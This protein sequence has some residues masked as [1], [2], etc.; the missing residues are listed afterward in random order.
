M[1]PQSS[2]TVT[3]K[4]IAVFGN[5]GGGKSRL[6]R[7]LAKATGLPL[8]C[9]DTIQFR[10]GRYWPREKGGGKLPPDEYLNLHTDIIKG[11]EWIVDGYGSWES[12]WERLAIADTL[13]YIDLPVLTTTGGSPGGSPRVL[14]EIRRVGRRIAPSG[15]ARCRA[16]RWFGFVTAG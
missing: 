13:V 3:M 4:R 10:S 8:Y 5:A 15:K 9:L 2:H 11:D 1:S 7:R 14:F 6:A 12:V 16:T